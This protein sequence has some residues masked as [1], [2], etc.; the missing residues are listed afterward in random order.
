MVNILANCEFVKKE[1]GKYR[2]NGSQNIC[3][4]L[5]GRYDDKS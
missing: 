4:L 5:W 2:I 1:L 3:E